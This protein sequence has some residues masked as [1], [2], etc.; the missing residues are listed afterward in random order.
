MADDNNKRELLELSA[1]ISKQ[2]EEQIESSNIQRQFLE[3]NKELLKETA[4]N[5]SRIGIDTRKNVEY[6]KQILQA[7]TDIRL[8]N[9]KQLENQ[10]K[11]Y[12]AT[13]KLANL[14]KNTLEMTKKIP[15]IGQG[16]RVLAKPLEAGINGIKAALDLGNKERRAEFM[17]NLKLKFREKRAKLLG[18]GDQKD[19]V[20][21]IDGEDEVQKGTTIIGGIFGRLKG[22][23]ITGGIFATMF[24]L[25]DFLKDPKFRDTLSNV[26]ESVKKGF[27][28]IKNLY[29]K[30]KPVLKFLTEGLLTIV[31]NAFEVIGEA[32]TKFSEGDIIGGV[33][34]L[35]TGAIKQAVALAD[36]LLTSLLKL[37]GFEG[38]SFFGAIKNFFTETIPNTISD[39]T[40]N[41]STFFSDLYTEFTTFVSGLNIFKFFEETIGDMI[42]GVKGIFAG[43]FSSENLISIFGSFMDLVTYPINLAINAVKDIFN[44]GDPN[45]PFRL[46][47]FFFGEDGIVTKIINFFKDLF[48]F[49]F[50]G[51][52]GDI[53]GGL[54][55]LGSKIA[56]WFGF[57]K[58]EG[59]GTTTGGQIETVDPDTMMNE[60]QS[61]QKPELTDQNKTYAQNITDALL[62]GNEAVLAKQKERD[63]LYE[64]IYADG[65]VTLDEKRKLNAFEQNYQKGLEVMNQLENMKSRLLAG[66]ELSSKEKERLASMNI[67]QGGSN[68]SQSSSSG[69]SISK[70]AKVDDISYSAVSTSAVY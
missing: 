17:E 8:F 48:D 7:N 42:D 39:I 24:L 47:D 27:E 25:F 11:T 46:S 49:D 57:S 41:I 36:L 44:W 14:S 15:L 26:W 66:E 34:T 61:Y 35:V 56:K 29:E 22:L 2:T 3:S 65:R 51:L 10:I 5:L 59:G 67:I 52:M 30:I 60:M 1:K 58:T 53:L 54:G 70:D 64:E 69:V 32:F 4:D 28:G 68:I 63:A 37:F 55:E 31:G 33:T 62:S 16:I 18:Q 13:E 9:V 23:L 6:Q 43:D 45:E 19:A 12:S 20:D 50:A 38:D 40:T 21:K